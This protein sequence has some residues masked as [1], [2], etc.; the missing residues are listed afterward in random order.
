MSTV[1]NARWTLTDYAAA[2]VIGAATVVLIGV[3]QH[4]EAVANRNAPCEWSDGR[5]CARELYP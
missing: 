3:V 5:T 4:L 2:V 1:D